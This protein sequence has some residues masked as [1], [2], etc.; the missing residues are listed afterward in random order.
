MLDTDANILHVVDGNAYLIDLF[1][2]NPSGLTTRNT[3]NKL[4]TLK[5]P[6][7][8]V[9]DGAG[10]N[11]R[12]RAILPQY[13]T[14]RTPPGEDIFASIRLFREA[15]AFIPSIV[16]SVPGWEA[17]DVVATI[18]RS[19]A[20]QGLPV[21]VVTID[22]DLYQLAAEPNIEVTASYKDVEPK[23]VRLFKTFVGD[24]SDKIAGMP[25]FGEKAWE[26]LNKPR[27]L[28]VMQG[29]APTFAGEDLGMGAGHALY[30]RDHFDEL[31]KIWDIVA[32]YDVPM[33]TISE[34][35][36]IGTDQPLVMDALLKQF[37][38]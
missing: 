36:V 16:V 18:A 2:F 37:L 22:R 33:E 15:L 30:Y 3:L 9:F 31:L 12:R 11:D 4:R 21:R 6:P 7:F 23:Y 20:R 5:L 34:R 35:W 19:R 32:L 27:A 1:R 26:K 8:F 14:N 13:K 10:G 38:L 29:R 25:R 17:D 28:A 24:P